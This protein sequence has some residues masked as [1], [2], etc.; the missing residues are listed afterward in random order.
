[1]IT[2][3]KQIIRGLNIKQ[4][5]RL[6]D[7]KNVSEITVKFRLSVFPVKVSIHYCVSVRSFIAIDLEMILVHPLQ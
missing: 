2:L 3:T 6:S 5:Y 7:V 4:H 1:M